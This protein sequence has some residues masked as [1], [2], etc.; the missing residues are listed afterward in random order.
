MTCSHAGQV[1]KLFLSLLANPDVPHGA[2]G[3]IFRLK[4]K[5]VKRRVV[6]G[7]DRETDVIMWHT[8]SPANISGN[9]STCLTVCELT[10]RPEGVGDVSSVSAE[11]PGA[12]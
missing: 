2:G 11:W 1:R 9:T 4:R 12:L 8:R 3:R 7:E 5:G 6:Q 10:T